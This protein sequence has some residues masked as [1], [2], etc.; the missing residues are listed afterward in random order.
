MDSDPSRCVIL[1]SVGGRPDTGRDRSGSPQILDV[2]RI[3]IHIGILPRRRPTGLPPG[4]QPV[5]DSGGSAGQGG[6]RFAP[7]T[8]PDRR[9]TRHLPAAESAAE[10]GSD[11]AGGWLYLRHHGSGSIGMCAHGSRPRRSTAADYPTLLRNPRVNAVVK[12]LAPT[13]DLFG[14]P[15]Q[16]RRLVYHRGAHLYSPGP[17]RLPAARRR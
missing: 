2:R 12:S 15:G 1:T 6:G 5:T 4:P 14:R 17:S 8:G 9:R 10:R 11:S 16:Q 13:G 3:G 7:A